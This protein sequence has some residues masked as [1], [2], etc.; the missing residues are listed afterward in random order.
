MQKG[1]KNT[2]IYIAYEDCEPVDSALP[3]RNLLRALLFGAMSD[4]KKNGDVNRKATE[5]F[6]SPDEEY[7]FSFRSICNHLDLDPKLVLVLV[8]LGEKRRGNMQASVAQ[9]PFTKQG[10]SQ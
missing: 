7:I 1:Q 10:S 8:G 4:L 2:A 6:L 5:F 9:R 3:E